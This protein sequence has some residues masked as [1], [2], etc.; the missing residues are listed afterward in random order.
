VGNSGNLESDLDHPPHTHHLW[1]YHN[2][3]FRGMDP[4]ANLHHVESS[5][6]FKQLLSEDLQ[7]ASLLYFWAP[8]A[9]PCKQM[10]PVV[11]ELSRKYQQLLSLHIEAEERNE[12]AESFDIENVPSFII[13]RVR[14]PFTSSSRIF[15]FIPPS[16]KQHRVTLY[17]HASQV[18]TPVHSPKPL[19]SICPGPRPFSPPHFLIQTSPLHLHLW[20]RRR[21]LR[22][23]K[24]A[25]VGS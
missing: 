21:R 8:W 13:L 20:R 14:Y 7:R 24:S 9:E 23:L 5:D 17:S 10:T 11:D 2:T 12:I 1:H 25:S 3:T 19:R 15:L 16:N 6:H 22:G 18:Q 4:P